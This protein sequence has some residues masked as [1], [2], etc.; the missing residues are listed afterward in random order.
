MHRIIKIALNIALFSFVG[1]FGFTFGVVYCMFTTPKIVAPILPS[2]TVSEELPETES[3][4]SVIQQEFVTTYD[5]NFIVLSYDITTGE[6]SEERTEIPEQFIGKTRDEVEIML[7]E[8]SKSPSLSEREKGFVSSKLERFSQD[9]VVV[10]KLY[11]SEKEE[12]GFFLIAEEDLIV[13]YMAD[14]ETIYMH[15]GIHLNELPDNT[16]TEIINGKMIQSVEELYYFLE[17]YTS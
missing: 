15:T 7:R 2:E 3:V 16:K 14:R 9:E 10:W 12:E 4:R 5:T 17:S 11:A 6:E 1:L 8:S 13:V